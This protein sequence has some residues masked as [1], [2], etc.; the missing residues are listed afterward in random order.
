MNKEILKL[1]N[2]HYDTEE[3]RMIAQTEMVKQLLE[4][5][6]VQ[7]GAK[8]QIKVEHHDGQVAI[9]NLYD[10]AALVQSLYDALEYFQSELL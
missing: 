8:I 6:S 7:P 3:G 1:I 5:C 4:Y 9:A 10:L 2:Q